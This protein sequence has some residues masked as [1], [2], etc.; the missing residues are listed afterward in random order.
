MVKYCGYLVGDEWLIQR[1]VDLGHPRPVTGD[2][3]IDMILMG[4]EHVRMS[5]N[6]YRYTKFRR[7]KTSKGTKFWCIAFASDDTLFE[8]LPTSAPPEERYK[9]LKEALQKT[10][11]PRW[12]QAA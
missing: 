5:T 1:V 9:A 2:D 7:V 6:V 4:A 8:R 10:G 11:P 3:R 12:Y